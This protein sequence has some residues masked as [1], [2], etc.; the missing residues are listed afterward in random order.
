VSLGERGEAIAR[1]TLRRA[2]MKVLASNYRC[3][4]GEADI[5]ALET[6]TRKLI[7]AETIAFVEVK[8][9][10]SDRYVQPSAAVDDRKR[11]QLRRVA[12]YYLAH[13][14]AAGFALRFDI[15]S[16]VIR[17]GQEPEIEHIRD[18]F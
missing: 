3:P 8:T 14:D 17:D 13:H 4:A 5:I 11:R 10:S 18:A 1:R 6:K 7:G 12:S 9:R 16:V 15:V 2:G